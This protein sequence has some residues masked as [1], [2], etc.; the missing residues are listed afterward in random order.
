MI[1]V[2]FTSQIGICC[3]D[4]FIADETVIFDDHYVIDGLMNESFMPRI[5]LCL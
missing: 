2:L 5:L 1:N 3:I 4:G